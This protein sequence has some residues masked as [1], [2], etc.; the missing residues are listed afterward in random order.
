VHAVVTAYGDRDRRPPTA[1]DAIAE[2]A[3]NPGG[4]YAR[5]PMFDAGTLASVV[6]AL[7]SIVVAMTLRVSRRT[8]ASP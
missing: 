6:A 4:A 3:P 2:V 1:I 8:G 7:A 5:A